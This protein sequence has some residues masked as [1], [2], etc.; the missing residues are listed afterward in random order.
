L[1][2]S[3][4]TKERQSLNVARFIKESSKETTHI[5]TTAI[6]RRFSTR[7]WQFALSGPKVFLWYFQKNK[8][9]I[10]IYISSKPKILIGKDSL[11]KVTRLINPTTIRIPK[12]NK[13][14]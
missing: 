8:L 1:I 7:V 10:F 12:L 4:S 3:R 6:T 2:L 11:L 5:H 13:S 14:F 9:D